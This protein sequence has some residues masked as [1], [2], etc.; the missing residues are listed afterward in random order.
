MDKPLVSIIVPLY[1]K[2]D[3]IEKCLRSLA[4]QTLREIEVI[5]VDNGSTDMGGLLAKAICSS[6]PRFHYLKKENWGVSRA[7]NTGL[8]HATGSFLAR[9]DADDWVDPEMFSTL[10]EVARHYQ[11]PHV[12][13]G[14]VREYSNGKDEYAGKKSSSKTIP[15]TE[16]LDEQYGIWCFKKLFGE[17]FIPLMSTC[18]G[19][20]DREAVIEAGIAFPDQLTNL[21][22]LF[23]NARFFVLDTPVVLIPQCHYHYR[24]DPDSL[25]QK[26]TIDL[27]EQL[28]RF[29]ELM[30]TEVLDE[31]PDLREA[32]AH[33]RAIAVLTSAADLGP[34]KSAGMRALAES[35]M[36]QALR[37][38]KDHSYYPKSLRTL[39]PLLNTRQYAPAMMYAR[40]LKGAR[41]LRRMMR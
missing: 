32:Y 36:Y 1:N 41:A 34:F 16:V 2:A 18:F 22:D 7:L 12:R 38:E 33:Y 8:S 4:A 6:D 11:A 39:M 30:Q 19:I 14:Y 26:V 27:A 23:F 37:D 40:S 25:S 24:E 35:A 15:V 9:V 13:G 31:H 5:V 20:I 29:E 17:V 28:G 21:E 10:Y 3:Y